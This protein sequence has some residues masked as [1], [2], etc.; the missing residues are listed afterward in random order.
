MPRVETSERFQ[1]CTALNTAG[2]VAKYQAHFMPAR[3]KLLLAAL[4]VMELSTIFLSSRVEK[5]VYFWPLPTKSQWISSDST[6][7]LCL[8]QISP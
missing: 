2:L 3:E 5:G 7:M 1:N 6:L 8:R 4:K